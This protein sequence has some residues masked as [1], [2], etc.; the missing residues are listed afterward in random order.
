MSEDQ[1]LKTLC[2]CCSKANPSY[3]CPR[4]REKY[5]SVDCCSRHKSVC[6]KVDIDKLECKILP[7]TDTQPLPAVNTKDDS[8]RPILLNEQDYEYLR[9][10]ISLQ[11]ILK[12]ERLREKITSIDSS[13]D[14]SVAL[15]KARMNP[16]FEEF[17]DKLLSECKQIE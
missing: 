6:Q 2:V 10:S 13:P 12:S 7:K 9:K 15:K 1:Q 14:R 5:C 16:E 4:C 11:R 3:R 8:N 17:V